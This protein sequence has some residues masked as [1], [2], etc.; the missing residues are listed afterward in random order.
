MPASDGFYTHLNAR[1]LEPDEVAHTFVPND[2]F[3]LLW[4]S[5]H[6]LLMGPRGCG[7]T[8]LLKMLTPRALAA[9]QTDDG[10]RVRSSIRY[11]GVYIPTDIHWKLQLD[12]SDDLLDALPRFRDGFSR[13]AVT[14]NVLKA[15]CTTLQDRLCFELSEDETGDAEGDLCRTLIS[16]WKLPPTI[17]SLE[18]VSLALTNRTNELRSIRN[19]V[20]DTCRRDEDVPTLPKFWYLDYLAAAAVAAE[21][22]DRLFAGYIRISQTRKRRF[23]PQNRA[24]FA[25]FACSCVVL[26]LR[27]EFDQLRRRSP[28]AGW[29]THLTSDELCKAHSRR[30][31]ASSHPPHSCK[32]F[33]FHKFRRWE[34][35]IEP[36]CRG[37]SKTLGS[38][39]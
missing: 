36:F 22:F 11:C 21:A 13:A 19:E 12:Y 3:D 17:P 1:D 26:D 14:T 6:A 24:V 25:R 30:G 28:G 7:K 31:A 33:V 10:E 4:Q 16:A 18:M 27:R 5:D 2:D 39:L 8:T 34:I 15:V 20:A 38:L 37:L 9:W 23:R 32:S 35:R 29:T